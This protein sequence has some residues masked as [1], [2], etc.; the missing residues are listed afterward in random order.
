[1]KR[2]QSGE[3]MVGI[4]HV[5]S[6]TGYEGLPWAFQ[7]ARFI[8]KN[9]DR[10]SCR[11]CGAYWDK[12]KRTDGPVVDDPSYEQKTGGPRY[13]APRTHEFTLVSSDESW[14]YDGLHILR[15][16]DMLTIYKKGESSRVAWSG[17]L[18]VTTTNIAC[19]IDE[20][21]CAGWFNEGYRA[22]LVLAGPDMQEEPTTGFTRDLHVGTA[23]ARAGWSKHC[24]RSNGLLIA[25]VRKS[26]SDGDMFPDLENALLFAAAAKLYDACEKAYR[27][28]SKFRGYEEETDALQEALGAALPPKKE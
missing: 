4:L 25:R 13:Y 24:V 23:R 7:D 17:K 10:F 5:H 3:E 27:T 8:E 22:R 18:L 14:S 12:S 9:T 16:G 15:D 28:L 19:D 1:M 20:A 6:E 2:A 21:V 26:S 11:V